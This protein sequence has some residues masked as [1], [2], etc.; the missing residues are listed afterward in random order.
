[1]NGSEIYSQNTHI[2]HSEKCSQDNPY[3]YR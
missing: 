3:V 2:L 1:M